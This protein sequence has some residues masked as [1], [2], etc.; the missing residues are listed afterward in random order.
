MFH[1][2][3]LCLLFSSCQKENQPVLSDHFLVTNRSTPI[4]S[5]TI[6]TAN[7]KVDEKLV[8][9]VT[10]TALSDSLFTAVV[11]VSSNEK[12]TL[13]CLKLQLYQVNKQLKVTTFLNGNTYF[14]RKSSV[15]QP[16]SSSLL[17]VNLDDSDTVFQKFGFIGEEQDGF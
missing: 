9:K 15:I 16:V 12:D 14:D 3:L 11:E 1:M 4:I 2:A 17:N 6:T 7:G 5:A 8:K 10:C 13:I